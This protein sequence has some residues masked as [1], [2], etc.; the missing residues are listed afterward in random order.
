VQAR[1]SGTVSALLE[2]VKPVIEIQ[3]EFCER[4]LRTATVPVLV[5]F[6][7]SWCVQCQILAT[8]LEAI[9]GEF[10]AELHV[11]EMNLD[12]SPEL[13]RR[14]GVTTVPTLMLFDNGLPIAVLDAGMSRREL[15]A[16]LH[17]LLADYAVQPST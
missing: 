6:A 12:R 7:T 1:K 3:G 16:Q 13:A 14:Y 17:G 15:K 9:A 10:G 2:L 8:L 11:A 4:E 5:H